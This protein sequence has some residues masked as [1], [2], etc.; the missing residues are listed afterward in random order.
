MLI[1]SDRVCEQSSGELWNLSRYKGQGKS[2]NLTIFTGFQNLDKTFSIRMGWCLPARRSSHR[3]CTRLAPTGGSPTSTLTLEWQP[4]DSSQTQGSLPK[5][6]GLF[7]FLKNSVVKSVLKQGRGG[8]LPQRL[9]LPHSSSP[10]CPASEL[11]HARLHPLLI[12]QVK[13]RIS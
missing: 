9:W 13:L 6:P 8:N 2:S 10:P 11:L 3:S 7:L 12:H 1:P 4:Q 5:L